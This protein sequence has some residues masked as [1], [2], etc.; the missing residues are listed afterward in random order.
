MRKQLALLIA[1]SVLLATPVYADDLLD[2]LQGKEA[3]KGA[4][5]ATTN[6]PSYGHQKYNLQAMLKGQL[7]SFN[8]EQNIFAS[9]FNKGDMAKA[10][11]QWPSA[12]D[13]TA[14][15]NTPTAK[16]LYSYILFEN[17]MPVLGV[18]SLFNTMNPEKIAPEVVQLWKE[19][20]GPSNIAWNVAEINWAPYWTTVFGPAA[21]VLVMSRKNFQ[22]GDVEKLKALLTKSAPDT[23]ERALLEWQLV[24]ALSMK[25][26]A[27]QA[28]KILAHLVK[29]DRNPIGADLTNMT[30][31]RLLFQNGFLDAAIE[32]YKKVDK[33]SD[34]WFDAQE[35]SAWTYIR[36]GEPQN[37]LAVTKTLVNPVF[38]SQIGPE[39]VFLQAMA[40]LKV[41]DYPGVVVSLNEYRE[42]FKPRAK[43]LTAL[44]EDPASVPAVIKYIETAKVKIPT[45]KQLGAELRNLPRYIT[46]DNRL[47]DLLRLE[48]QMD[49]EKKVAN[50]LYSRSLAE[51]TGKVGFQARLDQFRIAADQRHQAAHNAILQKIKAL[52]S[53]EL[54]EISKSLQKMQIVEAELLQQISISNRLV[55]T[56]VDKIIEKKGT[57]G[58]Q[59]KDKLIF[60]AE[61]EMWFDEL[62]NY[63][64]DVKKACQKTK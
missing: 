1:S 44:T 50:E 12:F 47:N 42:R 60:T 52:A 14:F 19:N 43:L 4:T 24:L 46:R 28:A 31:S 38:A 54:T 40:Q 62:S 32:Y 30:A 63:K 36:K 25:D 11:Y 37:T 59:A 8:A 10:L 33:S 34:Y 13:N 53:F 57:T 22:M 2:L 16:A 39:T 51:G 23:R 6:D 29:S 5:S 35:E 55:K 17:G 41:C 15:Q 58:S 7:T 49:I 56:D 61:N 20:L 45:L 3:V 48:K 64:V 27:Q 18:E 26:D 21:E 9:F